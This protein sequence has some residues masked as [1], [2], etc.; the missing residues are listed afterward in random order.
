MTSALTAIELAHFHAFGFVVLRQVL[1]ASTLRAE[2]DRAM[3]ACSPEPIATGATCVQYVPMMVAETPTSLSLLDRFEDL[4][5]AFLGGAVVPV[6]ATATRFIG[7]TAWHADSSDGGVESVAFSAYLDPLD[8]GN[9]ALRVIPGSHC[10]DCA[11]AIL[12]YKGLDASAAVE[13]WPGVA[14][15]T[16]PGDIIVFDEH[17]MHASTGGTVRQQWRVDYM[18]APTSPSE[19]AAAR[20]F[21]SRVFPVE[22]DGRY[23]VDR[24]PSYGPDWLGSKRPAVERLRNLGAYELADA[25]ESRSRSRRGSLTPPP[26][27]NSV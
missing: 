13:T 21:L 25:Q 10:G 24:F 11:A 22:W 26:P 14:I 18:R 12:R 9:G 6:R 2:V 7:A 4:A 23:D 3:V 15:A 16:R 1:D 27:S 8:A 20:A 5:A 19:E 17:L